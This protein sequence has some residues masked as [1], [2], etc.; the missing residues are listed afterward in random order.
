MATPLSHSLCRGFSSRQV[1]TGESKDAN[2]KTTELGATELGS[3]KPESE[4][5]DI[6][7]ERDEI[8]HFK[9]PDKSNVGRF[10]FRRPKVWPSSDDRA[11]C[12]VEHDPDKG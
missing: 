3:V 1:K 7:E 11:R 6:R 5:V 4:H 12:L 9:S 2:P 8:R 10:D